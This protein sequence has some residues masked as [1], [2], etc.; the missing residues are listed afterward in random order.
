[1]GLLEHHVKEGHKAKLPFLSE[2]TKP[3]AVVINCN[4]NLEEDSSHWKLS[5]AVFD[6]VMFF[7]SLWK[8]DGVY[9][10]WIKV[11][12]GPQVA[13]KYEVRLALDGANSGVHHTGEVFPIDLSNEEV[14]DVKY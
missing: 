12:G 10:A 5:V 8:R 6:E 9:Y 7:P 1:M 3:K 14:V 2:G 13:R 11:A 4:P